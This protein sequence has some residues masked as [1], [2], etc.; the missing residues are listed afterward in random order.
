MLEDVEDQLGLLDRPRQLGGVGVEA[1]DADGPVA[2]QARRQRAAAR[3]GGV[4]R[5][6]AAG[7]GQDRVDAPFEVLGQRA[8]LVTGDRRDHVARAVGRQLGAEHDGAS[9]QVAAQACGAAHDLARLEVWPR[10]QVL[11]EGAAQVL[12]DLLLGLLDGD[13]G[14]ARDRGEVQEVRRLG[15]RPRP[16]RVRIAQ[17]HDRADDVVARLDRDLGRQRLGDLRR[18][19]P[20]AVGDVAPHLLQ[21]LLAHA[22]FAA[23]RSRRVQPRDHD[24]HWGARGLRGQRRD[25][26]PSRRRPARRRPS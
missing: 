20:D 2:A 26:L 18:A 3:G 1:R 23:G 7:A 19:V 10:A 17:Q 16:G 12:L 11:Q 13:L 9:R 21:D 5:V 22:A 15:I 25:L 24:R 14:Q 4:R 8:G 6:V